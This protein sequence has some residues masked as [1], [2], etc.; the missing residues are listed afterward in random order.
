MPYTLHVVKTSDFIRYDGRGRIDPL[1]SRKL[2]ERIAK[3]CV[4]SGI[5][6]ALLDIRGM[7]GSLAVKDL[8]GLVNAFKEMGFRHE[9]RL[10]ILHTY[11]GAERADF[12]A[13]CASSRGW[14]VRAFE[15][16]EEAMDW[17]ATEQELPELSHPAR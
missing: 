12:F 9:H 1:R 4:D 11:T 7:H 3:A 2:L 6:C 15:N 10:A 8:Y 13:V 17:F 16:F 5:N 14:N